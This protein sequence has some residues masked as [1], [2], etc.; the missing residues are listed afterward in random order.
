M[1]RTGRSGLATVSA[2]LLTAIIYLAAASTPAAADNARW[3]ANY[4]PNVILTT[5][6]GTKVH[7][8]DDVIKGKSEAIDLIYT[9]CVDS[10]P[11][12]T[13]RLAHVQKMRGDPVRHDIFFYSMSIH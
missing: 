3:G 12:E 4:F 2:I 13:S 7:F 1:R 10:F 6:D 5:Q 11:L 9:S 8:Y